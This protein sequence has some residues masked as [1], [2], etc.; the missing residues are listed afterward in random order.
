MN[1]SGR[2]QKH[3]ELIFHVPYS[4]RETAAFTSGHGIHSTGGHSKEAAM[5]RSTVVFICCPEVDKMTFR[6][7][8]VGDVLY[9][10]LQNI[11]ILDYKLL[12]AL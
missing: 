8:E 4:F 2:P 1:L 11:H 6:D 10:T 7:R 12:G 5:E 9:D 3:R